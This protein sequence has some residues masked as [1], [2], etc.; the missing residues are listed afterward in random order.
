MAGSKLKERHDSDVF[1]DGNI[2][3]TVTDLD[4]WL[5]ALVGGK[6]LSDTSLKAMLTP[7]LEN[8]GYGLGI[9]GKTG[10]R[11]F[12][13]SGSWIGYRSW[14]EHYPEQD[15]TIIFN[16]NQTVDKG[17]V[18]DMLNDIAAEIL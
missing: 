7:G 3:T 11:K 18:K 1:T 17:Q 14:I 15:A 2:Y 4:R 12:S 16:C 5:S 13:H 10:R 6:I 8:Y 9:S